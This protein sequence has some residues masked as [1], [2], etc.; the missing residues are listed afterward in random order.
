MTEE[1]I[2]FRL[3]HIKADVPTLNGRVY[4]AEVLRK[5]AEEANGGEP[6][7]ILD[8]RGYPDKPLYKG[9]IVGKVEKSHFDGECLVIDAFILEGI[10]VPDAL[11]IFAEA[12]A[13]E[14][15]EGVVVEKAELKYLRAV[16]PD[17]LTDSN[18]E[19]EVE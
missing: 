1:K 3:E 16:E 4:S 11:D 6:L 18:A 17:T 9:E 19:A 15:K 5:M 7:P 2:T 12:E 8:C 10:V 13:R 14:S